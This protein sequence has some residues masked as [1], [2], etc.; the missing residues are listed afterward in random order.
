MLKKPFCYLLLLSI[1]AIHCSSATK[2]VAP[3]AKPNDP[4]EQLNRLKISDLEGKPVNLKDYVG[5]PVFLNFWA[6][7]CG[8]CVS[9]MGSVEKASQ[10]FK[11]DIVFL[12]VSNESNSLIKSFV[13]KNKYTFSF[14]HL[15]VNYV[16]A[17][18]VVLPTTFL[19]DAKGQLVEEEEGFRNWNSPES[20]AKLK[21]LTGK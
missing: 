7:W 17:F 8:P 16:D 18:V 10:Q 19:I 3:P 5:K 21:A 9:E 4:N 2:S 6:T 12:A 14:A 13:K 1:L 11:N 20:I 15:D